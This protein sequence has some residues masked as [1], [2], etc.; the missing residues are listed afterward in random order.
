MIK[1]AIKAN[2]GEGERDVVGYVTITKYI[3]ANYSV[4]SNF[5]RF[6]KMA[7]KKAVEEKLLV[8]VRNSFR[9]SSKAK[10]R[11][12]S[13]SRSRSKSPAPRKTRSSSPAKKS[14]KSKESDESSSPKRK[15]RSSSADKKEKNDKKEKK[16]RSASESPAK[17][18]K[19]STS[20]EPKKR[21]TRN[22]TKSTTATA[23]ASPSPSPKK[24]ATPKKRAAKKNAT[25]L[26]TSPAPRGE[27]NGVSVPSSKYDH[28]WQYEDGNWR[29]YDLNASDEVEKVYQGYLANRG[30][31]DVRAVKSGQWEYMVDFA[32]MKQTNLQHP[33]HTIRN[34][35]RVPNTGYVAPKGSVKETPEKEA[36]GEK[37]KEEISNGEKETAASVETSN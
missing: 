11:S 13:T 18:K 8:Q 14:K 1:K 9:L 19:R 20:E 30:D 6:V 16:S 34:V 21:S 17:K 35:R 15:T 10:K 5:K 22:S 33:N 23:E 26:P 25:T 12:S 2:V 31:T 4:G 7:L 28:V 24:T 32:A 29:N 36:T 37:G 3:A 27:R